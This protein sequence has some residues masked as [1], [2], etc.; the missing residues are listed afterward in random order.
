MPSQKQKDGKKEGKRQA[1][2][3]WLQILGPFPTGGHRCFLALF[4]VVSPPPFQTF[5]QRRVFQS[6]VYLQSIA[7]MYSMHAI[8][9]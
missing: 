6:T 7:L 5:P 8:M 1:K 4:N 2:Y 9:F 3:H